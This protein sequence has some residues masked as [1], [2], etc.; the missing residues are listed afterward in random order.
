MPPFGKS[1][2]CLFCELGS[3]VSCGPLP[4]AIALDDVVKLSVR[5]RVCPDANA[6]ASTSCFLQTIHFEPHARESHSGYLLHAR[7]SYLK[8]TCESAAL[9]VADFGDGLEGFGEEGLG[10]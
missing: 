3:G 9:S 2:F 1:L 7:S 5:E 8:L 10:V 4:V 6:L